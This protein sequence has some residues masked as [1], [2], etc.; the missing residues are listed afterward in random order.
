MSAL[1]PSQDRR[2]TEAPVLVIPAQ[3]S[4]PPPQTPA[5]AVMPRPRPAAV[6]GVVAGMAAGAA[7]TLTAAAIA[8]A[9][10]VVP[11]PTTISRHTPEPRVA[12]GGTV[13]VPGRVL[14]AFGDGS[15]QVGVDVAPGTYTT[16]GGLDCRHALRAAVTGGDIA[17]SAVEPDPATV[18]LTEDSGYFETSG[19]A[20]WRR[21]S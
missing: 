16:V 14:T 1:L 19:C 3:R 4:A 2:P 6:W 20:T 8:T 17:A 10:A 5:P 15:W 13:S 9:P 18:V 7:V 21:T 12:A 11:A